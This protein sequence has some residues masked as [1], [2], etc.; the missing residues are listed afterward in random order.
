MVE[1]LKETLEKFLGLFFIS[2]LMV[3]YFDNS[4]KKI[5]YFSEIQ[6][7]ITLKNSSVTSIIFS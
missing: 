6:S 7:E 2:Y 1:F 4:F 5:S 3:S